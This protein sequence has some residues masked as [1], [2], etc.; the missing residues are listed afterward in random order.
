MTS[1]EIE[2]ADACAEKTPDSTVRASFRSFS[3]CVDLRIFDIVKV[4]LLQLQI[5]AF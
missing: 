5:P 1:F 4:P 2:N 3:E